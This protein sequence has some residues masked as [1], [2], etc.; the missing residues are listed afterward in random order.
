MDLTS[1]SPP[2]HLGPSCPVVAW[3]LPSQKRGMPPPQPLQ[4]SRAGTGGW[5]WGGLEGIQ[6]LPAP[7]QLSPFPSCDPQVATRHVAPASA[8]GSQQGPLLPRCACATWGGGQVGGCSQVLQAGRSQLSAPA[9]A[10]KCEGKG[11]ARLAATF[12]VELWEYKDVVP[13]DHM[14]WEMP[15]LQLPAWAQLSPD[16][17]ATVGKSPVDA[18][19][20]GQGSEHGRLVRLLNGS[21]VWRAMVSFFLPRDGGRSQAGCP[22]PG[23]ADFVVM[24]VF[25]GGAIPPAPTGAG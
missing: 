22:V 5:S 3:W 20:C 18:R 12:P 25:P 2:H 14:R 13:K 8:K 17:A 15:T 1:L 19:S 23:L 7:W 11:R 9:M 21:G 10:G 6:V 16:A 4:S 24:G